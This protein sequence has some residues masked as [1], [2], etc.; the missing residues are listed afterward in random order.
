LVGQR[1]QLQ[2]QCQNRPTPNRLISGLF[3]NLSSSVAP[4]VIPVGRETA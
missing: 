2:Q 3:S 1:E 4:P